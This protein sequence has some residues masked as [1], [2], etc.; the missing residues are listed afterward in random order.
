MKL[1]LILPLMAIVSA[2]TVTAGVTPWWGTAAGKGFLG[3]IRATQSDINSV[4]STCY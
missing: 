2:C 4:T 1:A 3:G